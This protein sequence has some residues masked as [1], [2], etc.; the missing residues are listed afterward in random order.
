[1]SLKKY[2]VDVLLDQLGN[3]LVAT[4]GERDRDRPLVVDRFN[5][6]DVLACETFFVDK[7]NIPFRYNIRNARGQVAGVVLRRWYFRDPRT[8]VVEWD[9]IRSVHEVLDEL[10]QEDDRLGIFV[11]GLTD[12]G[13]ADMVSAVLEVVHS[14]E[15]C[16]AEGLVT[17]KV[18]AHSALRASL[19]GNRLVLTYRVGFKFG[20]PRREDG[21]VMS[22]VV[23]FD[24]RPGHEY[25]EEERYSRWYAA[26]LEVLQ[27]GVAPRRVAT[28]Y[29]E[30]QSAIG[31]DI[32]LAKLEAAARRVAGGIRRMVELESGSRPPQAN[33]GWRCGNCTLSD[34]CAEGTQWLQHR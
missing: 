8:S 27:V 19:L 20:Q 13:R 24:L 7:R 10:G 4:I 6:S 3:D 34:E 25:E 30:S 32:D 33:A 21:A 22:S 31:E 11:S 14:F 5:L 16:W 26:L 9:P 23:L 15:E 12:G 18:R 17:Q 29:A 1:M 2:L 28:W